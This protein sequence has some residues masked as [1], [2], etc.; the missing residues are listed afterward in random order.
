MTVLNYLKKYW[1]KTTLA[2]LSITFVS[3]L[4]IDTFW[5]SGF[6]GDSSIDPSLNFY[7]KAAL[8]GVSACVCA[9]FAGK[10]LEALAD[11]VLTSPKG[12]V[13]GIWVAS[14][15]VLITTFFEDL[16]EAII[17]KLEE[18]IGF[19]DH[20]HPLHWIHDYTHHNVIDA[21]ITMFGTFCIILGGFLIMI[22]SQMLDKRKVVCMIL[23]IL[24]VIGLVSL[25]YNNY[26]LSYINLLNSKVPCPIVCA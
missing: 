6:G 7:L 3:F 11:G 10:A 17:I 24:S 8:I 25:I 12:L 26:I 21:E 14:F 1:V 20:S 19:D 2:V 16:P 18:S 9:L 4:V 22:S 15:G 13:V 23:W 5:I